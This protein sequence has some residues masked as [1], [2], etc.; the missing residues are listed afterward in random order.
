MDERS[1]G[2]ELIDHHC[3]GVVPQDLIAE[4]FEDLISESYAP[5][6]LGTSHWDKPL[7]LSIR[8]WCAPM[9]DLPKFATPEAYVARRAELGAEEVNRRFL[10]ASGICR[11][12]VDSGNRPESLCSVTDME[13]IAGVLSREVVRMESV[14]EQVVFLEDFDVPVAGHVFLVAVV[15]LR[16]EVVDVGV[17]S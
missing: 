13:R 16:V 15:P 2:I 1:T 14:A 17:D 12:F 11:F 6:P 7:G 8:R 5:A 3:H 4:E 9:L 10:Q